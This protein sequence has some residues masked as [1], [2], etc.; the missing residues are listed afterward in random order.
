MAGNVSY[1]SYN[2]AYEQIKNTRGGIISPQTA[3]LTGAVAA[4]QPGPDTGPVEQLSDR[5]DRTREV[6]DMMSRLN[7]YQVIDCQ[8]GTRLK[9][10]PDL[11]GHT[12]RC[13]HCG[14]LHQA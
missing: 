5:V 2:Q 3:S 1:S 9:I 7:D 13:P 14:R 4:R 8:C 6:S 10:P 11:R 12:I